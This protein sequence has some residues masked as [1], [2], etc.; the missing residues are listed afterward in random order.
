MELF[1]TFLNMLKIKH[2]SIICIVG[3]EVF[4]QST[5]VRIT[6]IKRIKHEKWKLKH[7]CLMQKNKW[8]LCSRVI[9]SHMVCSCA[10][11]KYGWA[12]VDHIWGALCT[13]VDIMWDLKPKLSFWLN[14]PFKVKQMNSSH[15]VFI[16]KYHIQLYHMQTELSLIWSAMLS[17]RPAVFI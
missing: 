7:A 6:H 4:I 3:L 13:C 12:S 15:L 16:N 17:N 10:S 9:I 14:Y 1:F 8:S 2:I 11:S 5:D